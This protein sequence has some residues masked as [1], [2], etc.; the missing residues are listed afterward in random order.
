MLRYLRAFWLALKLTLTGQTPQ[1]VDSPHPELSAWMLEGAKRVDA[2]YAAADRQNLDQD[3]RE[4]IIIRIDGRDT[5]LEVI[6]ATIKY[7]MNEEYRYL[8][9]HPMMNNLGAIQANNFNHQYWVDRLL[10]LSDLQS[11]PLHSRLQALRT[12]LDAIPSLNP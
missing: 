11:D 5:S 12:H 8:I 3:A 10:A 1:H 6:L 2:V 4:E 7:A 9:Y